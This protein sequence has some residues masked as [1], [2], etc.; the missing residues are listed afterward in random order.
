MLSYYHIIFKA[1]NKYSVDVLYYGVGL[2]F[3]CTLYNVAHQRDVI[4]RP[5]AGEL[6]TCWLLLAILVGKYPVVKAFLETC[7]QEVS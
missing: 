1:I 2:N 3:W 5:I 7:L 4:R 6:L